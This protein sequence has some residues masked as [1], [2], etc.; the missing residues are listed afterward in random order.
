MSTLQVLL[1]VAVLAMLGF[2]FIHWT[3]NG[4]KKIE[5]KLRAKKWDSISGETPVEIWLHVSSLVHNYASIVRVR[6][7]TLEHL[8]QWLPQVSTWPLANMPKEVQSLY[9]VIDDSKELLQIYLTYPRFAADY[10]WVHEIEK[11]EFLKKYPTYAYLLT[12]S[13]GLVSCLGRFL[14]VS[15]RVKFGL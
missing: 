10:A 4:A 15:L 13:D 3:N 12:D 2:A 9:I 6:V 11:D 1:V 14:L 5:S 8:R 7:I